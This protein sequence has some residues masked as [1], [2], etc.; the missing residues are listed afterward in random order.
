MKKLIF[1]FLLG[2]SLTSHAGLFDKKDWYWRADYDSYIGQNRPLA[3]S[4]QGKF[5]D[6][7]KGAISKLE[8]YD[9]AQDK[10]FEIHLRKFIIKGY[11]SLISYSYKYENKE[12]TRQQLENARNEADAK[13]KEEL[14]RM[15][16]VEK[17]CKWE[18][19]SRAGN[20][21]SVDG[22]MTSNNPNK[23]LAAAIV[24]GF[25]IGSRQNELMRLCLDAKL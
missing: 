13:G 10:L 18:A 16:K 1:I 9:I 23:S 12:I 22:D 14:D 15:A 7:Y 6:Y 19:T 4:G 17:E 3:E 11:T 8:S 5:S 2:F 21:S 24:G 20:Y 25:E